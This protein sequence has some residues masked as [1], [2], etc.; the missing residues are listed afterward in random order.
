M[1]NIESSYDK[2]KH[3]NI[4]ENCSRCTREVLESPYMIVHHKNVGL[5]QPYEPFKNKPF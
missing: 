5:K 3:L 1:I 2:F 4:F